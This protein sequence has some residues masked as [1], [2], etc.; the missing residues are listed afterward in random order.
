MSQN[1]FTVTERD[2]GGANRLKTKSKEC[3]AVKVIACKKEHIDNDMR[4][5]RSRPTGVGGKGGAGYGVLDLGKYFAKR[6]RRKEDDKRERFKW[7]NIKRHSG[8]PPFNFL[9]E[10]E[11]AFTV[12]DSVD[13]FVES[14]RSVSGRRVDD[15]DSGIVE[16]GKR[17]LEGR[18]AGFSDGGDFSGSEII[19][20]GIF[21]RR[22]D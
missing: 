15:F 17:E 21:R 20:D 8:L 12:K 4:R 7:D 13:N 19:Y 5:G 14:G 6:V 1:K 2:E 16:A 22:D 9:L 18:G 11:D 3:E 10:E